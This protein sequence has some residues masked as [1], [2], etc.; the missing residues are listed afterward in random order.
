[1]TN[2]EGELRSI[3]RVVSFNTVQKAYKAQITLF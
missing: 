2:Q 1:M 3:R